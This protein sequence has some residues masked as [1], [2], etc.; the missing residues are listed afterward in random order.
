MPALRSAN[1]SDQHISFFSS[2]RYRKFEHTK[3]NHF[4]SKPRQ[5]R[6]RI[7]PCARTHRTHDRTGAFLISAAAR[8]DTANEDGV[9][10]RR[11]PGG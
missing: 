1:V 5:P 9:P 4:C 11:W 7:E 3:E 6:D 8:E 2:W 10:A